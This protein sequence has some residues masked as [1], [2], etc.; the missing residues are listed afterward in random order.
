M[1]HLTRVLLVACLLVF[2]GA[3]LADTQPKVRL[4]ARAPLRLTGSGFAAGERV[5]VVVEYRGETHKAKTS[6]TD[7]GAFVAVFPD[8]RI[9]RCGHDVE[10]RAT[11]SKGSRF[12]I[13]LHQ[14]A[15]ADT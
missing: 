5:T 2:A 12:Q 14:P 9:G 13:T 11:G 10:I 8:L 4:T 1:R 6:A 3:A 7:D 15:C